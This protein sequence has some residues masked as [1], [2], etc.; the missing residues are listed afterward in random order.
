MT[1]LTL[2]YEV[3]VDPGHEDLI[4]LVCCDEMKGMCGTVIRGESVPDD[5]PGERCVV[6]YDLWEQDVRCGAWFCLIRQYLRGDRR[7]L[8]YAGA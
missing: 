1:V 7:A 8:P 5:D 6:C 3:G 4:H 2:P